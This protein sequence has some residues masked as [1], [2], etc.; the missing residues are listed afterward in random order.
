MAISPTMG[1]AEVVW[2]PSGSVGKAG[3]LRAVR[4]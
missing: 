2:H 4:S 3:A 1:L